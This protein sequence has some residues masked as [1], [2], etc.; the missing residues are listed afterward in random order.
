[1]RYVALA[2]DYDGTLAHH[3][4]VSEP[5]LDAL[6]RARASG[7]KLIMVTGRELPDLQF[8]FPHL[9]L[10]DL[11]VAENGALLFW[12]AEDRMKI[13]AEP[14]PL[15]LC[16]ALKQRGVT[17]L[18]C[19]KVVIGTWRPHETTLLEVI[20]SLGLEHHIIF[21]KNAV[22]VL[23]SGVNKATGL[24]AALAEMKIAADS[25]VGVGDAENDHAFLDSCAVAAAVDNALA[26]LKE[27]CDLVMTKDHGDGVVEL[28]DRML[29]DDLASLGPRRP[30]KTL[31]VQSVP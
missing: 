10:F 4:R 11:V 28:I 25:V 19:G 13:L 12:P 24:A 22:M 31:V 3:G 23:P 30:R 15:A 26:S 8:A 20:S 17:P 16:E 27:H 14:P 1:M 6:R 2:T 21:N 18:S 5:T 29:A 9:E 7:R